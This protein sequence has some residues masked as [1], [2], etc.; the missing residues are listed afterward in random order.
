MRLYV[1]SDR[2]TSG[3]IT[4]VLRVVVQILSY[5][6]IFLLGLIIL[7][8]TPQIAPLKTHDTLNRVVGKSTATSTTIRWIKDR[9]F[10]KNPDSTPSKHLLIALVL[11]LSYGLFVALSDAGFLGLRACSVP[12]APFTDFPASIRSEADARAFNGKIIFEGA[13]PSQVKSLRCNSAEIIPLNNNGRDIALSC[14]SWVNSTYNDPSSFRSINLT[15]TEALTPRMLGPA[16]SGSSDETD[17]QTYYF[18]P[19]GKTAVEA[20][21]NSGIA[22]V[23]HNMGATMLLG[24]PNLAKSQLVNLPKTMAIEVSVGCL[25]LGLVGIDDPAAVGMTNK[26]DYFIP[27]DMYNLSL[28]ANFTGPDLLFEPLSATAAQ[29]RQAALQGYNTSNIQRNGYFKSVNSTGALY[30]WSTSVRNWLPNYDMQD[31]ILAATKQCSNLVQT[32]LNITTPLATIWQS[33]LRA[34]SALVLTGSSIENGQ[35]LRRYSAMV[36][37]STTSFKIVSATLQTDEEGSVT[38]TTDTIPSDLHEVQADFFEAH[39]NATTNIT[40]LTGHGSNRRF[41]L[42]DNPSGQLE[43]YISQS[44]PISSSVYGLASGAA[45]AGY[46]IAQIGAALLD[47]STDTTSSSQYLVNATFFSCSNYSSAHVTRWGGQLAASYFMSSYALNGFVALGQEALTVRSSGGRP[48][49]C[50]QLPY[51][52]AFAPLLVAAVAI[53]FWSFYM[54]LASKLR[55]VKVWEKRYGGLAPTLNK[56]S[57]DDVLAWEDAGEHSQLRLA[58]ANES[59]ASIPYEMTKLVPDKAAYAD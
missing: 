22:I 15:D 9:F 48:A 37:A 7:G 3:Q 14:T 38:A 42:S 18:G 26:T 33:S 10:V 58:H 23:P 12:F 16:H 49:V 17:L 2:L 51:F 8:N 50:Y 55:G 46:T 28:R 35:L 32:A 36:C 21:V 54:L 4:F 44:L 43:H 6:G 25:P 39:Y 27:D 5:G 13:D 47:P 11:S 20:K 56:H 45:S 19:L 41:T 53:I 24:A 30:S 31:D 52:A 57:P 29:I 40:S 1:L 34:C 59:T